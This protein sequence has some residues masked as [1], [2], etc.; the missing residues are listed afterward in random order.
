MH[1]AE[2]TD[3][4]PHRVTGADVNAVNMVGIHAADTALGMAA[5]EGLHAM[6]QLLLEVQVFPPRHIF[7]GDWFLWGRSLP[8]NV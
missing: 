4:I 7:S 5:R 1:A 6:L 8:R 2:V 3:L